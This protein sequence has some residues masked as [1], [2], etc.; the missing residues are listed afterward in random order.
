MIVY[1]QHIDLLSVLCLYKWHQHQC[2]HENA[3]VRKS[4]G[5]PSA[6]QSSLSSPPLF[7]SFLAP[8]LSCSGALLVM[9][10]LS[11]KL[12]N[13]SIT[14]QD[15]GHFLRSGQPHLSGGYDWRLLCLLEN[16]QIKAGSLPQ[17]MRHFGSAK[18]LIKSAV[19]SVYVCHGS[20]RSSTPMHCI[21]PFQSWL[22]DIPIHRDMEGSWFHHILVEVHWSPATPR[23]KV[24]ATSF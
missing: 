13:N 15:T 2:W 8:C 11:W 10:L 12:P 16:W 19:C 22:R 17:P 21:S 23:R 6:Y 9:L 24:P 1:T 3:T 4:V 14:L 20:S 18:V 7:L 5:Y